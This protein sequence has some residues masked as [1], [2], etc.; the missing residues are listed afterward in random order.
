MLNHPPSEIL[1]YI[2]DLLHDKP[3]T[4]EQCCLVAKSW[5][6]RSRKHLFAAIAFHAPS[7]L[8]TW[9]KTFPDLSDSPA[10]H[11]HTL[12]VECPEA[13]TAADA[14]EGGWIRAFSRVKRLYL[15]WSMASNW[16]IFPFHTFSPT[17]KFLEVSCIILPVSRL[18]DLIHSLPLLEELSILGQNATHDDKLNEPQTGISPSTSPTFTG[19]LNLLRFPETHCIARRL[20]EL[21][22]GLHFRKLGL[23]WRDEGGLRSVVGLMEACSGTL[24]CLDIAGAGLFC[25]ST[26]PNI[27]SGF[28]LQVDPH[29]AAHLTSPK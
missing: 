1:D 25:L 10:Y 17:L 4:L 16:G 23:S 24:E 28:G 8:E 13:V 14:E 2:V 18:F 3:E 5:V 11:T 7:E 26:G 22:N 21:P 12:L 6:P 9:K 15:G 19:T 29:P 27:N 20:L